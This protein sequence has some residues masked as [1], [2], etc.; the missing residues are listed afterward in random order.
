MKLTIG[1]LNKRIKTTPNPNFPAKANPFLFT[2]N[3]SP[4]QFKVH[5]C[6]YLDK[7]NQNPSFL[8]EKN[9]SQIGY[10]F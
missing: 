2:A 10:V 9:T 8:K 6:Y 7:A 5:S 4:S 1:I 3:S